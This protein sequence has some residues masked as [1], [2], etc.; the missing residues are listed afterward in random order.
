M[1][2]IGSLDI[3][4]TVRPL[5]DGSEYVGLDMQKGPGVDWVGDAVDFKPEKKANYVV[6]CETLEHAPNWRELVK[7]GIEWL[8]EDGV[9]LITCAGPGR[10]PHSAVDGSY[11]VRDFEHY[12]NVGPRELTE[13]LMPEFVTEGTADLAINV[14]TLGQDTQAVARRGTF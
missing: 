11:N 3:N 6:C 1:I 8:D 2:E 9:F 7:K 13:A 5:F 12:E 4:G 10:K 14:K